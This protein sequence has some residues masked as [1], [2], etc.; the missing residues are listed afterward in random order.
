MCMGGDCFNTSGL[1]E[2]LIIGLLLLACAGASLGVLVGAVFAA[3]GRKLRGALNGGIIGAV[4]GP[5]AGPI[6]L[7]LIWFMLVQFWN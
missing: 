3:S 1:A 2:A 7:I 5:I 4:V 6:V